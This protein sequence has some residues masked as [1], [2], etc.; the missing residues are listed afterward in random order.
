ML[1]YGQSFTDEMT[2][3]QYLD[4]WHPVHIVCDF[5]FNSYIVL[6]I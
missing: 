4:I 3:S 6:I 2:V 5:S 1:E